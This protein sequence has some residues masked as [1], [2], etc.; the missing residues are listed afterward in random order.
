MLSFNDLGNMGRPGNQMFKHASLKGIEAYHGYSVC[1]QPLG[2][3]RC[4]DKGVRKSDYKLYD[5][6]GLQG[7]EYGITV[8]GHLEKSTRH[9]IEA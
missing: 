2:K 1:M 7:V 9:L 3:P 5:I 6:F 4:S 8:Y